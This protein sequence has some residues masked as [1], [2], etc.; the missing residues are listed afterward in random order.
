MLTRRDFFRTVNTGSAV[1]AA[2][3]LAP[4]AP[5]E[6]MKV[7]VF[8]LDY[9]FWTIWADLLSPKGKRVGTSLLRMR[10]A[11]VWDKDVKLARRFADQWECEVVEKFDGMVGKVD[12]VLNGELTNV[13]FQ[14]L[15][16]RPYIQ[17]GIP[18]FLQ[19]HWSDTLVH[20]DEML[21]LAAKHSTPVMATVPFEHYGQA[22]VAV[23]QLKNAGEIQGVFAT[24]HS[25]DEPHFHLP[26]MMMKILGY[27][28]ESISMNVDDVRKVGYL[29][30]D[31]VYPKTDKRRPFALSMQGA[32]PDVFAFK[33]IGQH[34]VVTANMPA[35]S[36]NFARFFGQL[37]DIQRTFEKRAMYQPPEVMRKKFQ[38]L[39]TAYYS[40]LERNGAPVKIGSVPADWAIPAWTPGAWSAADF[41]A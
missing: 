32:G 41:K 21:D 2:T 30:V 35:E 40:R 39:Q 22:D 16:L 7:G 8:G 6:T 24:A 26:Y 36:D 34:G 15:L 38:C 1:L 33:I 28:V 4:A 27:D 10:P 37:M 9:T 12:A 11:Y 3:S 20:M 18:C 31:Y 25:T 17:A 14:H 19:R 29:S 23:E 13:P 5:I